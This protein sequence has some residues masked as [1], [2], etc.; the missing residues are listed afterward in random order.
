M[1]YLAV[2]VTDDVLVG[3]NSAKPWNDDAIDLS[4]YVPEMRQQYCYTIGL[5]GRQYQNGYAID[6]LTVVTRPAADGWSVEVAIPAWA[7]GLDA[8]AEG[9]E[10]PFTFA[11]WDDDT[12]GFPSQTH[13]IWEGSATDTY[14]RTWGGLA[15]SPVVYDF[16]SGDVTL[17]PTAT[18]S[19]TPTASPTATSTETATSTPATVTNAPRV[20]PRATRA[21]G[22]YLPLVLR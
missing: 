7:V 8:F 11:A 3:D 21:P 15:L 2:S 5:D 13:M 20:T 4:I 9:Q 14:V 1:L 19:T 12:F 16:P 6:W 10:Y 18:A 22:L 17:T